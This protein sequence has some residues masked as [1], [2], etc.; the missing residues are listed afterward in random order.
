MKIF[1][2]LLLGLMLISGANAQDVTNLNVA[3]FFSEIGVIDIEN[4]GDLDFILVGVGADIEPH[5]PVFINNGDGTFVVAADTAFSS[6]GHGSIDFY[7]YNSDGMLD[8][9]KNGPIE[10]FT[11]NGDGTFTKDESIPTSQDGADEIIC[12]GWSD[13]D[14]NALIDFYIFTAQEDNDMDGTSAIYFNNG[15]GTFEESAFTSSHWTEPDAT[16]V[17]FDNDGDIDL[18]MVA[19]DWNSG[20][21]LPY[22][23]MLVNDNGTFTETDL[24]IIQMGFGSSSW[25]DYDYDGDLDLLYNGAEEFGTWAGSKQCLYNNSEGVFNLAS[26]YPLLQFDDGDG[27]KFADWNNDGLFDLVV[28]GL[29]WGVAGGERVIQIWQN[30]GGTRFSKWQN[31]DNIPGI[32]NGSIEVADIDGDHDLDIVASGFNQIEYTDNVTF[33][34]MNPATTANTVPEAPVDLTSSV[35]ESGDVAFNWEAGSDT[36]SNIESLSYNLYLKDVTNTRWLIHPKSDLT[37]GK[38]LVV[39]QGNVF[40]NREWIIKDLPDGDYEWSVQTI[41]ASYAGS[42]FAITET[43][44]LPS[45]VSIGSSKAAVQPAY[46]NP[47]TDGRIFIPPTAHMLTSVSLTTIAGKEVKRFENVSGLLD[48]SNITSGMYLLKMD[49]N[50]GGSVQKI[51][52]Q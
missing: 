18:F 41:D 14:N 17:D 22:S 16:P 4:D 50:E 39:E 48:V 47:V 27:N 21:A 44:T 43:F 37:N 30:I 24:G 42:A 15:D 45:N 5:A 26:T 38:R 49:T 28:M 40:L 52:I 13:F 34:V 29:E 31:S 23:K 32:N 11:N 19:W 12:V 3:G 46:P 25:G 7:D 1:S 36:E 33:T 10:F 20:D 2:S 35:N 6:A 9:I 8:I 51:V